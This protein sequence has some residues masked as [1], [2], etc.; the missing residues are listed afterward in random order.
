MATAPS[1][2][3]RSIETTNAWQETKDVSAAEEAI[4]AKGMEIAQRIY[5]LPD[6]VQLTPIDQWR[7]QLE[8]VIGQL[9][10]A[11]FWHGKP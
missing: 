5:K 3:P 11:V 8:E 9:R 2:W 6:D 10:G 7:G 4:I 1:Q